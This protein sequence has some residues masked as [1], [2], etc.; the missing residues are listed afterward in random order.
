[1]IKRSDGRY[2]DQVTINGK[3]K[4]FYGK[5]KAEVK[6]KMAAYSQEQERGKLFSVVADEWDGKHREN[7]TYNTWA[8]YIAPLR[9]IKEHFSADYI[10]DITAGQI[11][12][13]V[14]AV[15]KKGYARRTVQLYLDLFRMIFDYAVVS[16]Y[17][18]ISP[19]ASVHMPGG[20]RS[21]KRTLPSDDDMRTVR[22]S[23]NKPF[24][25]FAYFILYSGLRRGELLALR[26]EDIDYTNNTI[27]VA[28]SV[29]Y[30]VNQ[31]LLKSPKTKAGFR[32]VI[33]LDVLSDKLDKNGKGYIFG[34]DKPLTQT[35]FRRRWAN[36]LKETGLNITPH[37]RRHAFATLC[38]EDEK[39]AQDLMGHTSIQVT[40]D[41]YTHIRDSRRSDTAAKLNEFASD[42]NLL[43]N[44][45][46][47]STE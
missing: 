14:N 2:Q 26:Y 36:Y 25:L 46:K 27:Q 37:Q 44:D 20:L 5:T 6:K 3:R 35:V 15:A 38:H 4:Y 12:P 28:K 29:Y 40:R 45:E 8:S 13:Y 42:V 7:V 34:G 33:L 47:I 31:P 24:G 30:E 21:G 17:A 39:A 23:V 22:E 11:Q 18:V 19:C 1:M 16:G 41:I 43:S 9:R 32:N 10:K